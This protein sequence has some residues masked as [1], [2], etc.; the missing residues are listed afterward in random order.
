MI[1][2]KCGTTDESD[3]YKDNYTRNSWNCKKC[4]K[5][6][7][8]E[9]RRFIKKKCVE[10]KGGECVK[11]GYKRNYSALEFHHV[12]DDKDFLITKSSYSWDKIRAELDKCIL[13]CSICHKEEHNPDYNIDLDFVFDHEQSLW[14]HPRNSLKDNPIEC[15]NCHKIFMSTRAKHKFCSAKCTQESRQAIAWPL[16]EELEILI[17]NGNYASV[18]RALGVSGNA[19]KN[20]CVIYGMTKKNE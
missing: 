4:A 18:G 10:Y 11:C 9:K 8:F 12:T 6:Y 2:K 16:K 3:F 7:S 17:N 5:R 13:L 19:V 15:K 14:K 1:C 20:R